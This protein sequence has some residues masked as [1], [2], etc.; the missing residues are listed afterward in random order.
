MVLKTII[1]PLNYSLYLKKDLIKI[2]NHFT[3]P[4]KLLNN[5]T[6]SYNLYLII[7]CEKN[8]DIKIKKNHH[9]YEKLKEN[10]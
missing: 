2:E 10:L 6:G 5:V 1:L 8:E 7:F 9:R 4:I 3:E